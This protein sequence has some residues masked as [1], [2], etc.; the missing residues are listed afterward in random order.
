MNRKVIA[1]SALL[2]VLGTVGAFAFGVGLQFNGN[3][4]E[5]FSP[6]VALTFKFEDV[7]LVFAVNWLIPDD[8]SGVD[9]VVGMTGDYWVV[10]KRLTRIGSSALN[11]FLGVGFFVNTSFGDE[12]TIDGGM[13]IPIGLNMFLADGFFEPFIQIAPSFGIQVIPQLDTTKAFFPVAAGFRMW[14]K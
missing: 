3:A 14:F 1:L 4:G 12:F 2:L 5:V 6:G 10:N 9:A 13:R 11:W 7:P 8:D